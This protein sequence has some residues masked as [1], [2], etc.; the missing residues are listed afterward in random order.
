MCSNGWWCSETQSE[1]QDSLLGRTLRV[2]IADNNAKIE[3][4]KVSKHITSA[5]LYLVVN[6]SKTLVS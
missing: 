6:Y 2:T 4:D 5:F 1:L 3:W